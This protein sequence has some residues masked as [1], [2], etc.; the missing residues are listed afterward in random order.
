MSTRADIFETTRN[1]LHSF[2]RKKVYLG[3]GKRICRN[4]FRFV[5]QLEHGDRN[6]LNDFSSHRVIKH[7]SR[8]KS[9]SNDAA[10]DETDEKRKRENTARS[11][12]LAGN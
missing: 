5:D 1:N 6:I 2:P 3:G 11:Y 12:S 7:A 8:H 10:R 4:L 9:R